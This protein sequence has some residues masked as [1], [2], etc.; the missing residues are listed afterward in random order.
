[1]RK[2]NFNFIDY[3]YEQ[4][5]YTSRVYDAKQYIDNTINKLISMEV[6]YRAILKC[7][8]EFIQN[9]VKW[10]NELFNNL[11]ENQKQVE[12][13]NLWDDS[14]N[15]YGISTTFSYMINKVTKSFMHNAHSYYDCLAQFINVALLGNMALSRDRISFNVL[16]TELKNKHSNFY[17]DVIQ[18]MDDVKTSPN[19]TYIAD[20]NN[21]LKHI[22][23]ISPK[24]KMSFIGSDLSLTFPSFSKYNGRNNQPNRHSREDLLDKMNEIIK[25]LEQITKDVVSLVEIELRNLNVQ[26]NKNRIHEVKFNEVIFE[27]AN[28]DK[29]VQIFHETNDTLQN[30]ESL[31]ILHCID[32]TEE[33]LSLNCTYEQILVKNQIGELIG[34][35][36]PIQVNSND[37]FSL[38]A[39]KEYRITLDSD[40]LTVFNHI[41]KQKPIYPV[42]MAGTTLKVPISN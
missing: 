20:A 36:T 10:E 42:V 37:E 39:Y 23:D 29:Q 38:L 8:K 3:K 15:Y 13:K 9:K 33:I 21:T 35:L 4:L 31:Y 30:G 40:I 24:I 5:L 7:S 6:D 28:K 12:I 25:E 19:F 16:L 2:S 34:Y 18:K 17:I 32:D 41:Q 22:H 26:Y 27:D 1:M 14:F 11:E